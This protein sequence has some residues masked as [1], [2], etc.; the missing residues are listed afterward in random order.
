MLQSQRKQSGF[1]LLELLLVVAVG[2]VL[3]L[4]GLGAYKLVSE[5]NAATQ[6][7]R[8]LQTLKQQVQ[9]A[10]QG[11]A[12]YGTTANADLTATLQAMRMLPPDMPL[13]GTT[14]RNGFSS[15]TTVTAGAATSQFV[16]TYNGVS[17]N[18]C[19]KMGQTYTTANASDFV[20]L[21][22]NGGAALTTPNVANLTTGA[23]G[24]D[25]DDNVMVW[26]FQ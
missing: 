18:A 5:G 25:A 4:A 20:S 3:I 9:Q 10:Y 8:Q 13:N 22:I 15:T 24:C 12:S 6:S 21:T 1:S 23:D 17:R 11:E 16:I 14:L 7:I 26:T 19:V 2:A